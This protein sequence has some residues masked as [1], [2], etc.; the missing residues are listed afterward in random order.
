MQDKAWMILDF[1]SPKYS[2]CVARIPSESERGTRP[3]SYFASL[4]TGI[5][6]ERG[7]ERRHS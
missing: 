1:Y 7:L 6:E 5:F 4:D 2:K 3:R